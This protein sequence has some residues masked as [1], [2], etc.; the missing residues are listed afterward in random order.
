MCCRI[1][2]SGRSTAGALLL[3]SCG[4]M[5]HKT[6]DCV[7][8]PRKVG[9]RWSN[10]HIAADEKVESIDMKGF[11]AK[12]DR[13]TGYDSK[14]YSRVIDTCASCFSSVMPDHHASSHVQ[15]AADLTACR[16]WSGL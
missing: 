11:E 4:A 15:Q 6:K 8:R 12:R 2:D 14:E 7:D 13:W 5:T 1:V 10:K 9:A 3:F 16:T